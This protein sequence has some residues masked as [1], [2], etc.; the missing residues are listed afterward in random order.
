MWTKAYLNTYCH[1]HQV[2]FRRCMAKATVLLPHYSLSWID[3]HWPHRTKRL[4]LC[5]T[6][7]STKKVRNFGSRAHS[8]ALELIR[9]FSVFAKFMVSI[10][11]GRIRRIAHVKN[12]QTSSSLFGEKM[13]GDCTGTGL[14]TCEVGVS[15]GRPVVGYRRVEFYI[16]FIDFPLYLNQCMLCPVRFSKMWNLSDLNLTCLGYCLSIWC[17][18]NIWRLIRITVVFRKLWYQAW[19]LHSLSA[20]N[21]VINVDGDLDDG[22]KKH[23]QWGRTAFVLLQQFWPI[24]MVYF[25][26]VTEGE[27]LRKLIRNSCFGMICFFLEYGKVTVPA[28]NQSAPLACS[29][30]RPFAPHGRWHG[31][32][33][34][35]SRGKAGITGAN[36]NRDSRWVISFGKR[37]S[38]GVSLCRTTRRV[39]TRWIDCE[40][41]LAFVRKIA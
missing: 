8:S 29:S 12:R 2:V 16:F 24:L 33:A 41:S 32:C 27:L 11:V 10:T 40:R 19:Y 38:R 15:Y 36:H 13:S 4:H 25:G 18:S 22:D 7:R 28:G 9:H 5:T 26:E 30:E 17:F 3:N 31:A 6:E 35:A 23:E 37:D 14:L 39:P 34:Y 21:N 20:L 1:G